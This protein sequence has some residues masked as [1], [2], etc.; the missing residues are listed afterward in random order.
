[1]R[2][3]VQDEFGAPSTVLQLRE[4]DDVAPG[5][6]EILVSPSAVGISMPD[7]LLVRGEY[8]SSPTFPFTVGSELAGTVVAVGPDSEYAV[9]DRVMGT[10]GRPG[11]LSEGVVVSEPF[12]NRVPED[13]PIEARSVD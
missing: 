7:L 11:G 12:A 10:G 5:R 1:M 8:Q 13:V 3:W 6:G 2:A 4:T 9:G